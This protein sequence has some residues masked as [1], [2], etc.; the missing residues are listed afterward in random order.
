MSTKESGEIVFYTANTRPGNCVHLVAVDRDWVPNEISIY[1]NQEAVL[2]GDNLWKK[3]EADR[4][5]MDE[6]RY[7]LVTREIAGKFLALTDAQVLR[8]L[9]Q[10][11]T[12]V[13]VELNDA[14][15]AEI[16]AEKLGVDSARI[17]IRN[18]CYSRNSVRA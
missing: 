5:W 12:A 11:L 9:S 14:V 1:T 3:A 16:I 4:A 8:T 18:F 7:R 2:R 6:A 15:I 13:V 17:E 10:V